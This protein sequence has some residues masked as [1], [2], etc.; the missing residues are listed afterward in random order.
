MSVIPCPTQPEQCDFPVLAD[1]GRCCGEQPCSVE[2]RITPAKPRAAAGIAARVEAAANRS[3]AGIR[4]THLARSLSH[5]RSS[6]HRGRGRAD[7]ARNVSP[8]S[9]MIAGR[10]SSRIDTTE[11]GSYMIIGGR[12]PI[13]RQENANNA[14]KRLGNKIGF[15]HMAVRPNGKGDRFFT[16]IPKEPT[17]AA[18]GGARG[19]T[20]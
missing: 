17:I 14:W 15:D 10:P 8:R 6:R 4:N 5:E 9:W 13:S 3:T 2:D 1:I 11:A 20:V 18:K 12:A 7:T 19:G 16:A